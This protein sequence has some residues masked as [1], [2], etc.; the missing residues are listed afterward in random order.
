MQ[1]PFLRPQVQC[2]Q[3]YSCVPLLSHFARFCQ[4][5]FATVSA[6]FHVFF[7]NNFADGKS[8]CSPAWGGRRGGGG[9]CFAYLES[10]PLD[11]RPWL[12]AAIADMGPC[13]DI[14]GARL[15]VGG[16]SHGKGG[17]PYSSSRSGNLQGGCSIAVR[18]PSLH[19]R[20]QC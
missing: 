7:C 6:M 1:Y 10:H 2:P 5:S 8:G 4:N 19:I 16:V 13:T 11:T 9:A 3:T 15:T 20:Q 17:L 12:P 18:H 14:T